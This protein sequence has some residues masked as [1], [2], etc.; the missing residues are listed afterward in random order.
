MVTRIHLEDADRADEA[1]EA[2]FAAGY[3]VAVV[4]ERFAGEDDDEAVDYV[5]ATPATK[6]EALAA[7]GELA[8]DDLFVSED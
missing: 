7:L 4:R 5:V 8:G 1:A 6:Q 2:L 3:E